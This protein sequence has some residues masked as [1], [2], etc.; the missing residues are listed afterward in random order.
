ML[1]VVSMGL[2]QFLTTTMTTETT[3]D[4]HQTGARANTA[5]L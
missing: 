2:F 5:L 3:I 4:H 1:L